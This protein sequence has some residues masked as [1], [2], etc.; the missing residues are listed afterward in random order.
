MLKFAANLTMMFNQL[1][2]TDRFSAAATAGFQ[3]VEFLFPYQYDAEQLKSIISE[4]RLTTV[5]FNAPPG[6]WENGERGIASLP[7]R[8]QE[9]RDNIQ[10]V[11]HYANILGCQQIHLMAGNCQPGLSAE[12]QRMWFIKRLRYAADLLSLHRINLLIEPINPTDMPDYFL[13]TIEQ[14]QQIIQQAGRANIAIQFDIY[15]RQKTEGNILNALRKHINNIGH[16]QIASAPDRNE[17]NDGEINYPWLLKEIERLNYNGWIGCEYYPK[18]NT[19]EGLSWLHN[20]NN[21]LSIKY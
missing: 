20:I 6:D 19:V 16:I 8:E 15:H 10:Q 13:K 9:F 4:Q 3:G 21:N 11:I 12:E 18:K 2:F 1:P 7:D 14:A 17:P 5:L